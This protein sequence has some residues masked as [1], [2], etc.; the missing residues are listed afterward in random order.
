[1]V[2]RKKVDGSKEREII[3][4][5]ITSDEYLA[6]LVRL[7][8]PSHFKVSHVQIVYKWCAE[9]YHTYKK[10]PKDDIKDMYLQYRSTIDERDIDTIGTFLG[11]IAEMDVSLTNIEY[12]INTGKDYVRLRSLE[13]LH[14]NMKH[15]IDSRDLLEAEDLIAKYSKVERVS[16]ESVNVFTDANE[17]AEAF[18]NDHEVLF[19]MDGAIGKM[20]GQVKRSDFIAFFGPPKRGKS[21]W[22]SHMGLEAVMKGLNVLFVSLEMPKHQM[23]RRI[24]T[25]LTMRPKE[26]QE[27]TIP[28]FYEDE[29]DSRK[30]QIGWNEE[31]RQGVDSSPEAIVKL[32]KKIKQY[33]KNRG[34]YRLLCLPTKTVTLD[35]LKQEVEKLEFYEK[36]IPD[37]IVI[38]YL[39]ILKMDGK[40]DFQDIGEL[41][42]R[43]RGWAEEKKVAIFS[44]GQGNR[45]TLGTAVFRGDGVAGS[46]EKM[47]HVTKAFSINATD[48]EK[49]NNL[50]RLYQMAEREGE[51]I[52][53]QVVCTA[54]LA[55][56]LPCIDS[57]FLS[58]V[59]YKNEEEEDG[60]E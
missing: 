31:V 40:G 50:Y 60:D 48:W 17:I 25:G 21:F 42:A 11:S 2:S 19:E 10:A 36:F 59:K 8:D 23:L 7:A 32:N 54:N 57:R 43:T 16:T 37:V 41:W 27:I 1:M 56:S 14:D 20:I 58:E 44:A 4:Y 49:A 22:L 13:L 28:Y 12:S 45:G 5:C 52:G 18:N 29:E 46:F 55:I 38:D 9:Y 51:V 39:D 35:K 24:Y 47:N 15:A 26:T 30:W 6:E 3:T 34:G 53:D 33:N